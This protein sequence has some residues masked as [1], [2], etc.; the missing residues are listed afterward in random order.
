VSSAERSTQVASLSFIVNN[1][2]DPDTLRYYL[3]LA[4][5][6]NIILIEHLNQSNVRI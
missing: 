6:V 2:N 5:K 3:G 1:Y 4:Q